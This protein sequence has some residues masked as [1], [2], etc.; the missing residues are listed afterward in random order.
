MMF[1]SH[2][3]SERFCRLMA[4]AEKQR[5]TVPLM[6]GHRLMGTSLV[7]TG[8]TAEGRAH[9]DQAIALYDPAELVRWRRDLAKTL[10]W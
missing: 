7:L 4:L 1:R 10:G 3:A 2:D 8:D 5:A 6:I 9:L